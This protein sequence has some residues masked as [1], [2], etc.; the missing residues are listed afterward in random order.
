M[1]TNMEKQFTKAEIAVTGVACA[2]LTSL[3][4]LVIVAKAF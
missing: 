1:S 4:A 2:L 3:F